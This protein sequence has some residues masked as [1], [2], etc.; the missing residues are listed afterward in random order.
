M[1]SFLCFHSSNQSAWVVQ[2][3]SLVP[4]KALPAARPRLG[5]RVS[6]ALVATAKLWRSLNSSILLGKGKQMR[7]L[8]I[9]VSR[10]PP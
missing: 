10:P 9:L 7:A 4:V 5:M 2:A 8:V 1:S 6:H 3:N